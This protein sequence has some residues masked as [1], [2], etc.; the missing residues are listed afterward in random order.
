MAPRPY[1]PAAAIAAATI[2]VLLLVAAAAWYHLGAWTPFT[3][4][5]GTDPGEW[6]PAAGKSPADLRFR[7]CVFTVAPPGQ[8]PHSADVTGILN[9]M[10]RGL[11]GVKGA[12]APA[13]LAL[14]RPLNPF[15][16]V[17]PGFND[18]ATV[19]A[20][21]GAGPTGPP[22]CSPAQS[23]CTP[24]AACGAGGVC[25]SNGFCSL[26]PGMAPTTLKGSYRTI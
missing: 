4:S 12:G 3:F 15:S 23:A 24:G 13:T 8:T 1:A 9:G 19:S 14:D 25:G 20:A 10:A 7:G 6:T 22:W 21:G 2:A 26:C 16:F 18:V 5:G 17:I 11:Q